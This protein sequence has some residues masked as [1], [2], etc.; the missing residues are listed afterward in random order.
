MIEE[1]KKFV[2]KK[3]KM[4]SLLKKE[5]EKMHKFINKQLRK[6]YIRSSKLPQ[7]ALVSFVEKKDNGKHMVQ[8][9]KYL[10]K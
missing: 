6:E 1:K 8:D 5:I 7:M 4:Y 3:R 10:N 2:P 9:Y